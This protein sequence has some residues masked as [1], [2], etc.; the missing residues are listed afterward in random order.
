M[1]TQSY[2][3]FAVGEDGDLCAV[4]GW[5][6]GVEGAPGL[7]PVVV[8]ISAYLDPLGAMVSTRPQRYFATLDEARQHSNGDT[9]AAPAVKS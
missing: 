6:P 2:P 7:C 4:V 1:F 5:E 9:R 3:L 8:D